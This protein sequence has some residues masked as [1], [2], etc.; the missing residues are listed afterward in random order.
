MVS[1]T[2]VLQEKILEVNENLL[3]ALL[4]YFPLLFSNT[5]FLKSFTSH[6]ENLLFHSPFNQQLNY[7]SKLA[8]Q[9][10]SCQNGGIGR[11]T[12]PP[13]TTKRRTTTN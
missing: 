5:G 4:L 10:P 11:Y 9:G 12:S 6:V 7:Q 1:I 2:E 3:A 13:C 8:S